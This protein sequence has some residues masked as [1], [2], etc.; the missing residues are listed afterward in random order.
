[1]ESPPKR[2][3]VFNVGCLECGVP[4]NVVGT[5]D[6]ENEAREIAEHLDFAI[7]W[8]RE[9]HNVFMVFDLLAAQSQEYT[10]AIA[11]KEK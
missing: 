9:G 11:N 1:M 2:W 3:L 10:D 8:R 7:G 4:S 5:Y 6:T